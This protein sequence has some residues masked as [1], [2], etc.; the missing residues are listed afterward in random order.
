[1]SVYA[2]PADVLESLALTELTETLH[3]LSQ[4]PLCPQKTVM[5]T[6][7]G[8]TLVLPEIISNLSLA[9]HISRR[10]DLILESILLPPA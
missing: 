2:E 10:L 5:R 1:M 7:D 9:V 3:L 6:S 4:G 8:Q